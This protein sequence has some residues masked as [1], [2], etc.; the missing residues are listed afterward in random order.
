MITFIIIGKNEG[1]KLTKC[2]ESIFDT[3]KFNKLKNYQVIYVDSKSTDD[4][5]ER[6]KK[7]DSVEIFSIKGTCNAAIA[8][9]IGAKESKG[10]VLFFV[11]GD[12]EIIPDFLSLVYNELHGFKYE[13]V[14]GD[15][16]NHFYSPKGAFLYK[17]KQ[18]DSNK[19]L[20]QNTTGGLFLI[21]RKVWESV[22]GMKTKFTVNED[23]DLGLRLSEKGIKLIR[24][25][26]LLAL[27][28]TISYRDASRMWK[29][30]F[31]G[32]YLFNVVLLRNHFMNIHE[33]KNYCRINYTSILMLIA[34]IAFLVFDTFMVLAGYLALVFIRSV[35]NMRKNIMLIPSR[36]VN[37]LV[38]DIS[39]WFA[40]F[41]FWP[42]ETKVLDYQQVK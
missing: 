2:I 5:I 40:L 7:F 16:E 23:L 39:L 33:L 25:K 10:D 34:I 15:F 21:K 28:H 35:V 20:L 18:F 14:S 37:F 1:W 24:K 11:D 42:R 4:S 12:M 36:F 27:H 41:L 8:R 29:M 38:R 17:K 32:T 30:I 9:N 22:N 26:E 13:F 3:I 31:N 19:D 6:V